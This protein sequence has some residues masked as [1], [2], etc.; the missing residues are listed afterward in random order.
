M[1]ARTYRLPLSIKYMQLQK[2]T[3]KYCDARID[4]NVI[5][6]IL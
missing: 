2:F 1:S 4:M 6:N 3:F 5:I